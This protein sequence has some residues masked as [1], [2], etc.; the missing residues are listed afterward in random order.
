MKKIYGIFLLA[1][2]VLWSTSCSEYLEFEETDLIAGAVALKTVE[3]NEAA[4]MGAYGAVDDLMGVLLNSVFSDEVKTAGE[5]YNASTTHEWKYGPADV[6]LRDNY[7]A[8][9]PQYRV[10]D[11]VNRV[12]QLV[13]QADSTRNGDN[14][15]R[16]RLKGEALFLRAFAH[17]ELYRFYGPKWNPDALAM[18][19]MEAPSMAAQARIK[20]SEY[21]AKLN[22]DI[23]D[24]KALLPQT[25]TDI[26]RANIISANGLHARI[27]LYSEDWA[28]A[29]A[30]ATTFINAVPL[31]TTANFSGIWTDA[32][33]TEVAYR[34]VRTSSQARPG[35]LFRNTSSG[36]AANQIGTIVWTVSNKLYDSYDAVNDIRRSVYF[37]TDATLAA[38]NRPNANRPG[39]IINKYR[40]GNY[41]T[42]TENLVN[43]KVMRVAEMYL[44]RAEARA[45]QNNLVGAASD[46]NALR[47]NRIT[48]YSP[49]VL[50]TKQQAIDEIMLERFKELAF[51]GHRF[52]DLKRRGLSVDR[53]ALDATGDGQT[54]PALDFRFALPIPDPEMKANKAMVQNDGY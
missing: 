18:P 30:Y 31:A 28:N 43:S 44:I 14:V 29:E 38:A 11:R 40:G 3:N 26:N 49:I 47:T 41:G 1:L 17:F 54:L 4:I 20:A 15:L 7:T 34:I 27:A 23:S 16:K 35:S 46:L 22:R 33:T 10:I 5:F 36:S 45:E 9:D 39:I 21:F 8:V 48:G 32:N 19:Y 42:A 12:L 53:L 13:D 37:T 24:A 50:S 2:G 25:M 6:G 51:E 52:W